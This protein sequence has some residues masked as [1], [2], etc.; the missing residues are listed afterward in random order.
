MD[1]VSLRVKF[2]N[3]EHAYLTAMLKTADAKNLNELIRLALGTFLGVV[4]QEEMGIAVPILVHP[5][6]MRKVKCDYLMIDSETP[7]EV[8]REFVE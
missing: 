8:P 6:D 1:E 5:N 2:T 7:L 3:R 4:I